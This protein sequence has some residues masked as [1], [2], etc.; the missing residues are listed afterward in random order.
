MQF[1]PKGVEPNNPEA[2]KFRENWLSNTVAENRSL[3]VVHGKV[4]S[5]QRLMIDA[6]TGHDKDYV[7]GDDTMI[8]TGDFPA[9]MELEAV[10]RGRAKALAQAYHE[11]MG[12]MQ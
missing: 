9:Q 2:I 1:V 12:G 10:F 3:G 7:E 5:M 4:S 6:F 8:I 11:Q